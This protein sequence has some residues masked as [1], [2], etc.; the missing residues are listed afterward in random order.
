[1]TA[2]RFRARR[3]G[4]GWGRRIGFT[5]AGPMKISLLT[6]QGTAARQL[7]CLLALHI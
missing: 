7:L 1:M 2:F 6:L 4:D 3:D 5:E